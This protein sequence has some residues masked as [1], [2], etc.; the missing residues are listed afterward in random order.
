MIRSLCAC[1][2]AVAFLFS[3]TSGAMA[4]AWHNMYNMQ[5]DPLYGVLEERE[6]AG[7]AYLKVPF[8]G[9]R[10][11]KAV[12]GFSVVSRLPY[13]FS[14]VNL[15]NRS[16]MAT[17]MDLQ[18]DGTHVDDLRINGLS[19]KQSYRQLSAAGDRDTSPWI[20]Y[21]FMAAALGA[22]AAVILLG[23]SED[24]DNPISTTPGRARGAGCGD[25]QG[26]GS[27]DGQG[28][29]V[30]GETDDRVTGGTCPSSTGG[31]D[32]GDGDGGDDSA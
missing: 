10:P 21:G 6:M 32:A 30:L 28:G 5:S 27:A 12:W 4:A 18:F 23:K 31:D 15:G 2:V 8:S 26:S 16:G 20:T 22:V 7:M 11:N 14:H 17:L 9:S 29:G 1:L 25:G 19:A 13:Q 24:E 3:S